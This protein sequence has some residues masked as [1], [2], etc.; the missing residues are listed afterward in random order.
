MNVGLRAQAELVRFSLL[1]PEC[2][3]SP[4]HQFSPFARL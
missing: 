3:L 1:L 2:R 4:S